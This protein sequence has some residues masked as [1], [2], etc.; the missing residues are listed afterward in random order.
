MTIVLSKEQSAAV[1]KAKDWYLN[2]RLEQPV[3]RLFGYAG[4]G[5]STV[6]ETL[7][8][9]L[10][11]TQDDVLFMAP[12]GR[13]AS[14]M[15]AKGVKART[16]HKTFYRNVGEDD[17]LYNALLDEA[18]SIRAKLTD[19][20]EPDAEAYRRRLAFIEAE[21]RNP[22]SRPKPKYVFLGTTPV[23][24]KRLLVI[25]E[26][27]MTRNDYFDDITSLGLPLVLV[28]DDG[29][30]PAVEEA[31]AEPSRVTSVEPDVRLTTVVRQDEASYILSLAML[32][33]NR[34]P[35]E[36]WASE[37]GVAYADGRGCRTI[38]AICDKVDVDLTYFDKIV[39][40][41]HKLRHQINDHMKRIKGVDYV[42]PTGG[43]GEK[44]IVLRNFEVG[45]VY[46]ANGS[47]IEVQSD[48][49][50]RGEIFPYGSSTPID[51]PVSITSIDG[52]KTQLD[53]VS[54]W[55][56]P[57]EDPYEE[58]YARRNGERKHALQCVQASWAWAI[59]AHK[60]QGSE[61]DSVCVLDEGHKFRE[62][63]A[64]WRYTAFT[65]ARKHLLVIQL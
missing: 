58:D 43:T 20:S 14:V 15:T 13:A 53:G 35:Y 32:A 23:E 19:P 44:L 47:E 38:E 52:K 26:A 18:E 11:L 29:Q 45:D 21:L 1:A 63:A 22:S 49:R 57:F 8:R 37:D 51:W 2:H 56:Y 28:G 10:G 17:T 60:A 9:R 33:R 46:L 36:F 54:L 42:L 65:R 64:R 41:T 40:G 3:F 50:R 61:W 62:N 31:G 24:N 16:I 55:R 30:L 6:L 7:I 34:E 39:C 5:K 48:T 25:D 12:T 27:S 4:T 59:T